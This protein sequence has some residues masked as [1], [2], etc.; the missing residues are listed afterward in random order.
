MTLSQRA[1]ERVRIQ[2]AHAGEAQEDAWRKVAPTERC[3]Y[4]LL[5]SKKTAHS[6]EGSCINVHVAYASRIKCTWLKEREDNLDTA[7]VLMEAVALGGPEPQGGYQKT[8]WGC[9][10]QAHLMPV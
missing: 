3:Y 4:S 10:S 5:R 7:E 1:R 6:L 9:G 8:P 2:W